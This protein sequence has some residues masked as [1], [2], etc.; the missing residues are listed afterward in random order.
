MDDLRSGRA[1][2]GAIAVREVTPAMSHLRTLDPVSKGARTVHLNCPR[3]GLTITPKASSL[4]VEHCPRCMAR[5]GIHVDLF[6]STLPTAQLYAADTAPGAGRL[7]ASPAAER[8][9]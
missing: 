3:C 2:V 9:A 5:S 7:D 1:A 8:R 6:A 4:T